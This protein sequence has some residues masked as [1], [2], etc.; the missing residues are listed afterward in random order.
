[1]STMRVWAEA[2]A[3]VGNAANATPHAS[4]YLI[5]NAI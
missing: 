1:M 2:P 3:A 4:K 5:F